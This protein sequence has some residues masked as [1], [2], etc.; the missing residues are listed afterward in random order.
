[1]RPYELPPRYPS[2]I[3]LAGLHAANVATWLPLEAFSQFLA[4]SNN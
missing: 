2:R 3:S 1:M 4:S